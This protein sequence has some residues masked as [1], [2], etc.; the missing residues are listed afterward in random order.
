M[1]FISDIIGGITEGVDKISAEAS[2]QASN[3]VADTEETI[4]FLN[5][6]SAWLADIV[7]AIRSFIEEIK[8]YLA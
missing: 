5:T 6:W 7:W 1:G 3:S 4:N 2:T 8:S